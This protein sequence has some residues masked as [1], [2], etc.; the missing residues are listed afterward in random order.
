M[1]T[2]SKTLAAVGRAIKH[3]TVWILEAA[4]RLFSPNDDDYPNTGVQ[5]FEGDIPDTTQQ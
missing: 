4:K 3:P 5:P 1:G 2:A